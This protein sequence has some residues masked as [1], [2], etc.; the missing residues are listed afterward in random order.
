MANDNQTLEIQ[1]IKIKNVL[2]SIINDG[3]SESSDYVIA[4]YLL[5]HYRDLKNITIKNMSNECYVDR[6]TIRRFFQRYGFDNFQNFKKNYKDDF[7][8]RNL[9]RSKYST[10]QEY[11]NDL[12]TQ[13]FSIM[14]SYI[15]SRNMDRDIECV[16]NRLHSAN[17][18]ALFGSES[19]YGYLFTMQQWLLA[20]GKVAVVIT[21]I[22]AYDLS[23]AGLR[24][25]DCALIFSL[26]GDYYHGIQ[27]YIDSLKCVKILVTLVKRQEFS[28]KF[29]YVA[30]L[31]NTNDL[32]H[33]DV[34]R[35]YA[36]L[37]FIDIL[38]KSYQIRFMK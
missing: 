6:A 20:L 16:I 29:D 2:F 7:E 12:N 36:S 27:E 24:E 38:L 34:Y 33:L 5:E 13:I 1:S 8:S 19:T 23:L 35:K 15:T 11:I 37:Y 31:S 22:P 17:K 30:A 25:D 4:K 3:S 28:G 9:K 21:S 18:V 14:Q 32:D 26:T 10:Y